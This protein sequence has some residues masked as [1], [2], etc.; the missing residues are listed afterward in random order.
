MAAALPWSDAIPSGKA[1][2]GFHEQRQ[3]V[4][5]WYWTNKKGRTAGYALFIDIRSL[6]LDDA[7]EDYVNPAVLLPLLECSVVGD[8]AL[9]SSG[10]F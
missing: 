4:P 9:I 1:H 6:F 2:S 10:A 5:L 3:V 8:A 7:I